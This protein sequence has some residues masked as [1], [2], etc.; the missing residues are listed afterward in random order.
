MKNNEKELPVRQYEAAPD[1]KKSR[2]PLRGT[3]IT[4]I[5]CVFAAFAL[6]LYVMQTESPTY[7]D[8]VDGIEVRLEGVD[9]LSEKTGL[10]VYSG[11]GT[12]V[13]VVVSGKKSIIGRLAPG[14]LKA[15]VDVSPIS[16]AGRHPLKVS[17][18]MP[19]GLTLVEMVP[20][21]VTVY[22]DETVS[23]SV[24]VREKM[25]HLELTDDYRLGKI[26]LGFDTITV[27]GPSGKVN[28][29]SDAQ[30]IIDM[31]G[32]T[33]SFSGKFPIV[34]TDAVGSAVTM[35]Y[36][37]CSA[38]EIDVKVPIYMIR[39]IAV[40]Y[41][42]K[43]GLLGEDDVKV[44]LTPSTLTVFGD[45]GD[46]SSD[47]VISP[48]V[49]DEKAITSNYYSFRISPEISQKVSLDSG[50]GEVGVTVEIDPSL[51]TKDF[52]VSDIRIKGAASTIKCEIVDS[53]VNVTLRG[54]EAAFETMKDSDVYLTVDMTGYDKGSVGTVTR[55][56]AVSVAGSPQGVFE[57]GS[58]SVKVKIS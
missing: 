51:T 6:W 25:N 50:T 40:P 43:Y 52:T 30:V 42:F 47:G 3:I 8:T 44:T 28:S 29:V 14:D 46:V 17:I 53:S 36:L 45:A 19:S 16:V 20:S 48:V 24:P 56:A 26:E 7:T 1:G 55:P 2:R 41:E 13:N 15:T 12:T 54:T 31:G 58:Y 33:S 37:K 35:D 57:I 49:I 39:E 21:T 9:A 5:L 4:I 32:K 22:A 18:D 10:S 27:E 11:Q 34:L 38:S 23:K